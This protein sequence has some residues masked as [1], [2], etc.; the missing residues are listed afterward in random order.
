MRNTLE[1]GRIPAVRP[2]REDERRVLRRWASDSQPRRRSRAWA[3]LQLLDGARVDRVARRVGVHPRTIQNWRVRFNG[4]GPGGL[5]PRKP[6]GRPT[7]WNPGILE[8]VCAIRERPPVEFGLDGM[9]WSLRRLAR[10]LYR[11]R[12][13]PT[14]SPES[15]RHWLRRANGDS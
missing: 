11:R 5:L 8:T 10:Y 12:I 7:R 3:I 2:P 4:D 14:R 9:E 13:T 15:L 6:P 1:S